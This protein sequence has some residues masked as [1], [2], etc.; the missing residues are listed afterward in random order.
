MWKGFESCWWEVIFLRD[1]QD[2]SNNTAQYFSRAIYKV[3]RPSTVF[4][5]NSSL[6]PDSYSIEYISHFEHDGNF[7]EDTTTR[8]RILSFGICNTISEMTNRYND[9]LTYGSL[10]LQVV[11]GIREKSVGFF[12]RIDVVRRS[13][14]SSSL[15]PQNQVFFIATF[16]FT[17]PNWVI[18][19]QSISARLPLYRLQLKVRDNCST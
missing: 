14:V 16:G 4:P 2:L 9:G 15:S 17:L 18:I 19:K 11:V 1:I 7:Q 6:L 13:G 8:T 10:L 12:Q 3:D 5:K